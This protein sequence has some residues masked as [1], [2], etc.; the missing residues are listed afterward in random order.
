MERLVEHPESILDMI[1]F[2]EKNRHYGSTNMNDKSSRSHVIVRLVIKRGFV[3]SNNE[4]ETNLDEEQVWHANPN[5]PQRVS[6]L[7][8]VDLAGSEKVKK[9]GATG[10]QLKESNAINK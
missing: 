3:V 7:N 8:F 10:T 9:T 4:N 5:I 1:Q 6:S 2:G